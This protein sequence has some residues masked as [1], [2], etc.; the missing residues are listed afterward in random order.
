MKEGALRVRQS[1][2][3]PK[4]PQAAAVKLR[5]GE[6]CGNTGTMILLKRG[7]LVMKAAFV[8]VA[9]ILGIFITTEHGL[10]QDKPGVEKLYIAA[11]GSPAISRFGRP[12]STSVKPWISQS[13][14][15]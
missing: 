11:K 6:R 9:A 7:G 3:D 15:I 12:A 1:G 5:G 13:I 10:A 14:A 4:P 8:L 2:A